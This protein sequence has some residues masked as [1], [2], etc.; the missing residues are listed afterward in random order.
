M[1]TPRILKLGSDVTYT[2][3]Q[4]QQKYAKIVGTKDSISEGTGLP[5]LSD[6]QFHIVVFSPA[7][8]IYFRHNV[9]LAKSVKDNDGFR[10]SE[11]KL[12]GVVR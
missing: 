11:G 1:P 10:N 8:S 3:T 2:D 12:V 4:G 5:T 7:G 6:D 9:P